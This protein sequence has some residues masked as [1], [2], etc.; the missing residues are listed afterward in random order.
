[1]PGEARPT[2]IAF[3]LP[4]NNVVDDDEDLAEGALRKRACPARMVEEEK[5][6]VEE[7][8]EEELRDRWSSDMVEMSRVSARRRRIIFPWSKLLR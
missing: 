3:P 5:E 1:M 7:E 8:V 6:E 4:Y 2:F